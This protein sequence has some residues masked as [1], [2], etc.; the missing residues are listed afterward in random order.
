MKQ[1]RGEY[2]AEHNGENDEDKRK[3]IRCK[4]AE[5]ERERENRIGKKE[6]HLKN[7]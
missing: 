7:Y 2:Q 5:R 6:F 4:I 1:Y 3:V